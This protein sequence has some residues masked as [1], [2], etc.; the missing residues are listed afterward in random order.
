MH[1]LLPARA[2]GA[3]A[4]AL[5]RYLAKALPTASERAFAVVEVADAEQTLTGWLSAPAGLVAQAAALCAALTRTPGLEARGA[6]TPATAF[7]AQ[8]LLSELGAH[9]LQWGTYDGER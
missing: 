8:Y 5:A 6:H 4:A 7:G 9:G 2:F 3:L 1:R